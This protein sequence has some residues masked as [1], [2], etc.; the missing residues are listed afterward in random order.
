[1][2]KKNEEL[3]S[4]YQKPNV[5]EAIRNK[6][7]QCDIRRNQNPLLRTVPTEKK[8]IRKKTIEKLRMMWKKWKI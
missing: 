2:V 5:V 6:K 7:L 1:M 3:E 8:H 4:L